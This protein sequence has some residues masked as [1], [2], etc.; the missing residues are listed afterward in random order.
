MIHTSDSSKQAGPK[1][2]FSP[3]R[4]ESFLFITRFLAEYMG[5]AH[6]I[7]KLRGRRV[8]GSEKIQQTASQTRTLH[9]PRENK[10]TTPVR[11]RPR[12]DLNLFSLNIFPNSPSS[13]N[14]DQPRSALTYYSHSPSL[15]DMEGEPYIICPWPPLTYSIY[16]TP[17]SPPPLL[18][19]NY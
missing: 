9:R 15:Q 16:N 8:K 2:N 17:S 13:P 7:D 12:P 19:K 10:H 6:V 3:I 18:G 4:W 14:L 11:C 1:R 5:L